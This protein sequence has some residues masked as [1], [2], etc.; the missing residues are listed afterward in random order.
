MDKVWISLRK[1]VYC[2]LIKDTEHLICLLSNNKM[3]RAMQDGRIQTRLRVHC[4]NLTYNIIYCI[5]HYKVRH[6]P[7][8]DFTKE[9]T[10][11][12]LNAELGAKCIL[13]QFHPNDRGMAV[14]KNR[15]TPCRPLGD[16]AMIFKYIIYKHFVLVIPRTVSVNCPQLNGFH[17]W[18]V[19]TSL[20]NG[21]VPSRNKPSSEPMLTQ[22]YV[23]CWHS[24]MSPYGVTR[25]QWVKVHGISVHVAASR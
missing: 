10:Y 4:L 8:F 21:L 24:S 1:A 19:N 5:N 18:E 11:F 15:R 9:T 17:W 7:D 23:Q 22:L 6:R 3:S 20:G 12:T 25:P 14:L 16:L 13:S 2:G